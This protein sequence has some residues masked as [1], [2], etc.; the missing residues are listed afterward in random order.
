MKTLTLLAAA[1]LVGSHVYALEVQSSTIAIITPACTTPEATRN[2]NA[3]GS[4]CSTHGGDKV[5]GPYAHTDALFGTPQYSGKLSGRVFYGTDNDKDGCT[6]YP[7][8]TPWEEHVGNKMPAI[9]LIDRG[10]CTFVQKVR[11]AQHR[12]ANAVIIVDKQV[13]D[14]NSLPIMADDGSGEDVDIP[15]V[16][17]SYRDGEKIKQA[18]AS[19]QTV[20][21]E[22]S[23]RVPKKSGHVEWS[24]WTSANDDQSVEFVESFKDVYG[25]LGDHATL[26]P[27]FLIIDGN[28]FGCPDPGQPC[29][30][31][32]THAGLYCAEDPEHDFDNGLDGSDI[33]KEN[34]RQLCIWEVL[35]NEKT[36][37]KWWDYVV[38]F[39]KACKKNEDF[40][41]ACSEE[42]QR[43]TGFTA[44][45]IA[46]IKECVDH[47]DFCD[48]APA[49]TEEACKQA[50]G[51]W[52]NHKLE[53]EIKA[54]ADDG[55]FILPTLLVNDVKYRGR[56]TC[57]HPIWMES[58]GPLRNI[59][60]AFENPT[61]AGV[62][63]CEQDYCWKVTDD[64][65]DCRD[66][67]DDPKWNRNCSEKDVVSS[68]SQSSLIFVFLL[69]LAGMGAAMMYH[70]RRRERRMKNYVEN[71]VANYMPLQDDGVRGQP[72]RTMPFSDK[73]TGPMLGPGA[74]VTIDLNASPN[75]ET[76]GSIAI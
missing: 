59:C 3:D 39:D 62:E 70:V 34:L 30:E 66:S 63:V 65:G 64:C 54:R 35:W 17:I 44:T 74:G 7:T 31:Q 61:E 11:N 71:I 8:P 29:G 42:Q 4:D 21:A 27:H 52:K 25:P 48:G 9:I 41:A 49:H 56:L 72:I 14:G 46:R 45:E 69:V 10:D 58:C 75:Q 73:D 19:G 2:S 1:I 51:T 22:L 67:R 28:L 38:R 60:N 57:P 26:T 50:G 24:F 68:P 33:V 53:G 5:I 15:A 13:N 16:F 47:S 55:I 36:T 37:S 12:S 32:C 43:Q 18:L 20:G 23:W 76:G 6:P 40:H